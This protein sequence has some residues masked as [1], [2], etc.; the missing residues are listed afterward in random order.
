[1]EASLKDDDVRPPGERFPERLHDGLEGLSP[2][3]HRASQ[4]ELFESCIREYGSDRLQS[5]LQTEFSPAPF[6]ISDMLREQG[7]D[8]VRRAFYKPLVLLRGQVAR[9]RGVPQV[10]R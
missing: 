4:R 2:H 3:E 1:M 9:L 6:N 8:L 5:D 7:N 10:R